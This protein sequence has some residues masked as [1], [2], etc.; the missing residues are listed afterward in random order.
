MSV[1]VTES[2]TIQSVVVASSQTFTALSASEVSVAL[3]LV[4]SG[5][6]ETYS[7]FIFEGSVEN[8]I[9]VETSVQITFTETIA[10][11]AYAE[12]EGLFLDA[13][14]LVSAG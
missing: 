1:T 4:V 5:S 9:S 11:T 3:S 7:S 6:T 2:I 14:V 13:M 10:A 12:L 8:S